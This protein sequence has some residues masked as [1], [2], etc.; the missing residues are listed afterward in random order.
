MCTKKFIQIEMCV[1]DKNGQVNWHGK[2]MIGN[3]DIEVNMPLSQ[4]LPKALD[5]RIQTS[6]ITI[7]LSEL[8]YYDGLKKHK[9]I[10]EAE[11]RYTW[12]ETEKIELTRRKMEEDHKTTKVKPADLSPSHQ[13]PFISKHPTIQRTPYNVNFQTFLEHNPEELQFV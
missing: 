1:K 2:H 12:R 10:K 7:K 3:L 11:D 13:T 4:G 5:K 6:M 8:V 9:L